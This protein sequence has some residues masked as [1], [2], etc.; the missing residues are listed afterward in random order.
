MRAI[1]WYAP[2]DVR[3]ES[4]PDPHPGPAEVVVR[5]EW[6]GLCGTDLHEYTDGPILIPSKPHPLTGKTSPVTLGHE[7]AGTVAEVGPEA[8]FAVGDRVT[9]NACLVCHQCPW[10]RE[11]AFNLCAKL[12]SIGLCADGGF[13]ERVTVPAY[14]VHRLPDEL[15]SDAAA[16]AEPT[17]VAVH[18]CRRARLRPG[19]SVAVVGA[20]TIGLL[21]LQVARAWGASPVFGIEPIEARRRLAAELGAAQVFDPGAGRVDKQIAAA[22]GDRRAAVV[23][24]CTGS[25]AGLDTALRVSGKGGRVTIV[26]IYGAPSPA[27]WARLQAHEKEIVGSSAYTDEFPAALEL[28]AKGKVRADRMISDRIPLDAAESRGLR[29][30]L[31]EPA[32]HLKIL[33]QP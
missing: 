25:G 23:F 24:E 1:R 32:A 3:L 28:L 33:V 13:A 10:C 22:T 15:P 6:C 12:G 11:K 18:A 20:G 8:A 17:S 4:V 7:F 5:V 27:P 2:G 29:A 19:D 30:L 31:E 16:L 21:V 14:C 9:A 26:G